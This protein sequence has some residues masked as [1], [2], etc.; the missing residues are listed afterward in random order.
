[1]DRG[2]GALGA[3]G[4]VGARDVALAALRWVTGAAVAV[5][6][7]ATW[8][9]TLAADAPLS[10][11]LYAGTAGVLAALA[12][13]RLSGITAFDEHARAAVRRLASLAGPASGGGA[14]D[15]SLYS[16]LSGVAAAL[17]MWAQVSGDERAA[18]GSRAV[19][20]TITGI[21]AGA[22]PVS[23]SRDLIEGEAG[24]LLVLV[25]LGGARAEQVATEIAGRL[26]AG[27]RWAGGLPDWL[28]RQGAEV[29]T[30][31]FSHGA[32]GIGYALAAASARLR[33]PDLL[34]VAVL[35]GR[36]LVELG[37][38]PDGTLAVPYR[39]PPSP[40]AEPVSFGWCHG[41][42]GTMRLF[43]VLDVLR[44]GEG[45]AGWVR[46]SRMAVRESG[47]PARL[48]PGFWD[49]VG[50]CCGTA[51]VGEMALDSY[52]ETG[53]R[54][55]LD[56]AAV[57]ARDALRRRIADESGARWSNTEYRADP[58]DLEPEVG[59]MQGAA[60]IAGWLLRLT[61]VAAEGTGARRLWW[62]DRPALAARKAAGEAPVGLG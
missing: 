23:P 52:Q 2:D 45:W 18:A 28:P 50:Q 58:P 41:P 62:P 47:L 19:V 44:P 40:D 12:E 49:N 39:S 59:W 51:G 60:G 7:G 25:E 53:D 38:R 9:E 42:T 57:L 11:D 55:W 61:R 17:H 33:R 35:A 26:V 8:R 31:N 34:R 21:A 3:H 5:D 36:R 56:W 30:P 32:A 1:M 46:A 29:I 15:L 16:G 22:G 24:I 48:R 20:E 4:A 6:G 27:A 13:A 10:D 37:T 43:Q 54:E 14:P